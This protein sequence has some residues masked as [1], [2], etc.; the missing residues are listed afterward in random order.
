MSRHVS[1]AARRTIPHSVC[2]L[3]HLAKALYATGARKESD[4]LYEILQ[5]PGLLRFDT[6]RFDTQLDGLLRKPVVRLI[7]ST[8]RDQ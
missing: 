5:R 1:W 8:L 2:F 3:E 7:A 6:L 4:M